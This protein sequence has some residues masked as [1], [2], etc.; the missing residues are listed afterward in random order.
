MAFQNRDFNVIAYAN[1][2]TLWQYTASEPI[3]EV[4]Q[5]GYFA[6]IQYLAHNGDLIIITD[7]SDTYLRVVEITNQTVKLKETK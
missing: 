5:E 2:F 4:L 1:S 3:E 7:G 6:P